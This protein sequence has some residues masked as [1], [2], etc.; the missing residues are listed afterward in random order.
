MFFASIDIQ[1]A[2]TH[3]PIRPNLHKFLTFSYNH[4]LY[5][6]RALPF[7]LNVAPFIFS[8]ILNWP[9][10]SLREEGIQII[11]Y[12]DDLLLWHWN[13]V[14][15]YH[16]IS[17]T[18]EYLQNLGFVIN[19][20]KSN[21]QPS[22]EITWLG[23]KWLGQTGQWQLPLQKQQ[24]IAD[25]AYSLLAAPLVTRR[26]WEGLLGQ[27]NFAT[28]IHRNLKPL[29]NLL[30]TVTLLAKA[31]FR[32][33]LVPLPTIFR[34]PLQTWTKL[35]IWKPT[36]YFRSPF[37]VRLMWTDAS[38]GAWGALLENNKTVSGQ[39]NREEINLHINA[40]EL[41][42]V[43]R[44]ITHFNLHHLQLI[45]HTD[46]STVQRVL[47]KY[48]TKSRNLLPSL[49]QLN[50]ICETRSLQL[51]A[52]CIPSTLNVVADGLSRVL[53][54]PT[55]WRLP[56]IAFKELS[57]W[58]GPFNID[59]MATPINTH[60]PRFI[61]PFPHPQAQ[62]NNVLSIDW[63]TLEKFYMF[64]PTNMIP[65]LLP[66]LAKVSGSGVLVAPRDPRQCGF[67]S[68]SESS[69]TQNHSI[70]GYRSEEGF[71]KLGHPPTGQDFVS[72][73]TS[74]QNTLTSCR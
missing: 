39:W 42:A 52:L 50:H 14:Q 22:T 38:S 3:V 11:G 17:R 64:P 57:E 61:C 51:S 15:L 21:L 40:L 68:F 4:Q 54:L 37:P 36:P 9:L 30:A 60:L 6:F 69:S 23:V 58:A 55:E 46:N 71:H 5:S 45:I 35:D 33:T 34:S 12:I 44:A 16:H 47:T 65:R 73:E 72:A 10:T 27:I 8:V 49:L 48:S 67:Q 63:L 41:L 18:V 28:Q 66:S 70:P 7:G 25:Q 1:D 32:D 26:K 2:Y 29:S 74:L 13:P 53:P 43:T 20:K 31:R 24:E 19:Q 59:L 56:R 62:T